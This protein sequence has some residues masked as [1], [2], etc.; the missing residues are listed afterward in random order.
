VLILGAV[1]AAIRRDEDPDIAENAMT[2]ADMIQAMRLYERMRREDIATDR[3]ADPLVPE[4]PATP[5]TPAT[6]IPPVA[7]KERADTQNV[8]PL[9]PQRGRGEAG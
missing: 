1:Y 5:A 4:A 8:T 7:A 2:A 6:P 9:A 3:P